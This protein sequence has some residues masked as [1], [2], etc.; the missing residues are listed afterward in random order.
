MFSL[1]CARTNRWVNNRG[2]GVLRRSRSHYDIIVMKTLVRHALSGMYCVSIYHYWYNVVQRNF[3]WK[4]FL[5]D[6]RISFEIPFSSIKAVTLFLIS[7][8][9]I[10][11][12]CVTHL[13]IKSEVWIISPCLGEVFCSPCKPCYRMGSWT[14][15]GSGLCY[16]NGCQLAG[17]YFPCAVHDACQ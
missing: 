4:S 14:D 16:S 7:L 3:L 5:C 2:V 6:F 9:M 17:F 10:V 13:I 11:R 1:I 12:I 8:V 15:A